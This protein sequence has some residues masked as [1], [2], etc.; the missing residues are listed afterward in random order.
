MHCMN[1]DLS[2]RLHLLQILIRLGSIAE[3]KVN[4][5]EFTRHSQVV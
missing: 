5:H 2:D 3:V 4:C 1:A